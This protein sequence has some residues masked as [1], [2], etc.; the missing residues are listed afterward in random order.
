MSPT[1]Q[2]EPVPARRG[3]GVYVAAG[4]ILDIVAV[5]GRQ[6]GDLVAWNRGA[7]AEYMSPAHTISCNASTVLR[8]GSTVFTNLRRPIFAIVRDDV[9]RHDIIVPCCDRERYARDFGQ[10]DHRHCLGNLVEACELLGERRPIHGEMAWNVFM[11]NRVMPD[12]AVVT[13]PA[14]HRPGATIS[15]RA[16]MDLVAIL[17][18]CP[19][20]L[21]PCNAFN[22][23]SMLMRIRAE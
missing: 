10:P 1:L 3:R 5:E 7:P 23:T 11:H 12:G 4:Q 14:A 13:E 19:Q 21:T 8:T 2:E 18:A 16:E 22:P 17:S 20:D 15:L 9:E 6:V